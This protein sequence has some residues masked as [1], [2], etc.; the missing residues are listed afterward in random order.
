MKF[1]RILKIILLDEGD[2]I[3]EVNNISLDNVT[4]KEAVEIFHRVQGP[5][6][7]LLIERLIV[8]NSRRGSASVKY[9]Y[10][11]CRAGINNRF[12]LSNNVFVE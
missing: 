10:P 11:F 3:L 7:H 5:L 2:K 8:P 1:I 12:Y 4:H 9:P 6:C